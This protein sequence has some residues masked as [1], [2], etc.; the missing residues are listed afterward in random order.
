[1]SAV[2]VTVSWC[3]DKDAAQAD[4]TLCGAHGHEDGVQA[5]RSTSMIMAAWRTTYTACQHSAS[6]SACC[7]GAGVPASACNDLHA[8][9]AP[10]STLQA[11]HGTSASMGASWTTYAACQRRASRFACSCWCW[12]G[13]CGPGGSGWGA[14]PPSAGRTHLLEAEGLGHPV[15]STQAQKLC[16]PSL[17]LC[18]ALHLLPRTAKS[19]WVLLPRRRAYGVC[20]LPQSRQAAAGPPSWH[21]LWAGQGSLLPGGQDQ[22]QLGASSE[23]RLGCTGLRGSP[24]LKLTRACAG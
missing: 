7:T 2:Q 14:Q 18:K 12:W 6:R 21:S 23:I 16:A 1:M 24:A 17:R 13:P 10:V 4:N 20:W 11:L 19:R 8:A 9:A 22:R 3:R 5:L 15:Q